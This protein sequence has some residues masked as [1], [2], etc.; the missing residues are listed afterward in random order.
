MAT[1]K[2]QNA[3]SPIGENSLRVDARE[4][5]TGSAIYTDDIQF[6]NSL[7]Y[8]RIKRSPHPHALIKKINSL[9]SYLL[10]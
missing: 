8:A 4:K 3:P 7:L 10:L 5:V 2:A 1:V 9:S 6:G